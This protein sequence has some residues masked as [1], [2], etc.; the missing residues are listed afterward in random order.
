MPTAD[1]YR[2]IPTVFGDARGFSADDAEIHFVPSGLSI[3]GVS[4]DPPARQPYV[5]GALV[6]FYIPGRGRY[7][8]SLTPR[9]ELGFAQAG[10]VRGGAIR[11]T[12]GGDLPFGN[13]RQPVEVPLIG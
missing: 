12:L 8:L 11:F 3:N 6:W 7:I 2:A 9:A 1:N 5:T 10:E 13:E 4:Q